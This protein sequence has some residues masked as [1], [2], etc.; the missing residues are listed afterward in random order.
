[1][2]GIDSRSSPS[3]PGRRSGASAPPP[4]RPNA[5]SMAEDDSRALRTGDGDGDD[6]PGSPGNG[7][8]VGCGGGRS[9][10]S[11][12]PSEGMPEDRGERREDVA[13]PGARGEAASSSREP[14]TELPSTAPTSF[15]GAAAAASLRR[16]SSSRLGARASSPRLS[17]ASTSAA[18][19]GLG[20]ESCENPALARGEKRLAIVWPGE[21]ESPA[22]SAA[23]AAGSPSP[24]ASP[25]RSP[26]EKS[27]SSE[28]ASLGVVEV[29]APEKGGEGCTNPYGKGDLPKGSVPGE[30]RSWPAL[31][32]PKDGGSPERGA[33]SVCTSP[34]EPTLGV[35]VPWSCDV[36]NAP[37]P[38]LPATLRSECGV[39]GRDDSPPPPAP[40]SSHVAP[41]PVLPPPPPP[42]TLPPPPPP[43]PLPLPRPLGLPGPRLTR[44]SSSASIRAFFGGRPTRPRPRPRP[45]GRP[46][47]PRPLP[48]LGLGPWPWPGSEVPSPARARSSS[49]ASRFT[50]LRSRRGRPSSLGCEAAGEGDAATEPVRDPA[51]EREADGV[52]A[53]EGT[54]E[55]G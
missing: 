55:R 50:G 9:D 6:K 28:G 11:G 42:R 23:R 46:T 5:A 18:A 32:P 53:T 22:V 43:P 34:G 4:R 2:L 48:R 21:G 26:A 27:R 45:G 25:P 44:P 49:L 19:M 36:G 1:M 13:L 12:A 37:S 16:A 24:G 10:A 51:G 47:R 35:A 7:G 39:S 38:D 30:P 3:G 41:A 54:A 14:R 29:S 15:L 20:A 52:A 31:P 40:S 17:A 8:D 33:Y